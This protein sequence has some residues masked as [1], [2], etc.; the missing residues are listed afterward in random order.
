[1]KLKGILLATTCAGLLVVAGCSNSQEDETVATF[2][3]GSVSKSE[4]YDSMVAQY[5]TQ[6]LEVL[7]L[8]KV[9]LQEAKKQDIKVTKDEIEVEVAKIAE[10]YGGTDALEQVLS[11]S[12][13]TVADIKEDLKTSLLLE[14]SLSGRIKVTDDEMKAYFEENKASFNTPEQ[15]KASHILVKD[16]ETANKLL[17]DLQGGADFAKLAKDKSTDSGSAI[18]GG[19]LGFFGKGTMVEEFEK[20]AFG[21]EINKLSKVVKTEHGYHII[22]VTDKKA[23]QEATFEGS[24]DTIRE[25]LV[26]Q[27]MQT[28]YN[29]W[30]EEKYK[31]YK[32]ET[33]IGQ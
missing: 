3:G 17:K 25:T 32:V 15:I 11:A 8:D 18:E 6:A 7:I 1:M 22:K 24:K 14:K 30:V 2:E 16:Q 27:K 33:E 21:L 9:I 10:Q 12:N 26:D 4:L 19:D 29:T 5:G 31:E 13:L 20:E 23:A 28:E